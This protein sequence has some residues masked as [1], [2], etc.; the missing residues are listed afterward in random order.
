MLIWAEISLKKAFLHPSKIKCL[1]GMKHGMNLKYSNVIT[2]R[3][4]F[5]HAIFFDG[6]PDPF[7]HVHSRSKEAFAYEY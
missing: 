6:V 3:H 7:P 2:L 1:H 5:L 4:Y